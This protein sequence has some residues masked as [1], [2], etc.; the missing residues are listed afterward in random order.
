MKVL[1]DAVDIMCGEAVS[2][3]R[4]GRDNDVKV[5]EA[6]RKMQF[7]FTPDTYLVLM[8][9]VYV[10]RANIAGWGKKEEMCCKLLECFVRSLQVEAMDMTLTSIPPQ[11]LSWKFFLYFSFCLRSL[12]FKDSHLA[13]DEARFNCFTKYR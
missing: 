8:S 7:N 3:I 12:R 13:I 4:D 11:R 6:V 10:S 5:V 1:I 2:V 9:E